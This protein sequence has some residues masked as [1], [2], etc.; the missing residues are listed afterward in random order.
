MPV[1]RVVNSMGFANPATANYHYTKH[2]VNRLEWGRII[3]QAAYEASALGLLKRRA[4][5]ITRATAPATPPATAVYEGVHATH[6]NSLVR[7]DVRTN[8]FA[9]YYEDP[10]GSGDYVIRTLFKPDPGSH[11]L[12]TNWAYFLWFIT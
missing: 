1:S 5:T 4:T 7:Y 11:S 2:V 10:A 3:T 12:G 9:V 8:R 6:G